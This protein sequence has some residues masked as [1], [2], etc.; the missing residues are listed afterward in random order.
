[1][2]NHSHE[3]AAGAR[4]ETAPPV[5][6]RPVL[7]PKV[8]LRCGG[9][10]PGNLR[11]ALWEEEEK[12]R[13]SAR[14][15]SLCAACHDGFLAGAITRVEVAR[16][17]HAAKNY[18]P[19]GWIARIDRD[20]LLAITCLECGTILPVS[21]DAGPVFPSAEGRSPDRDIECPNCKAVNRMRRR[22]GTWITAQIL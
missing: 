13:L 5:A 1:M 22:H 3:P 20:L 16:Q 8:C 6:T 15:A 11:V 9:P 4:P 10:A 12:G 19:H 7:D 17:Y 18:E 21:E 2:P 14:M